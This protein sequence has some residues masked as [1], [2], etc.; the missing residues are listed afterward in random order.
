[1]EELTKSERIQKSIEKD[2]KKVK[3]YQYFLLRLVALLLLIWILLFVVIGVT[4]MP[5]DDMYPRIDGGDIIIFYRLENNIMA[6]DVVVLEKETP[7][8][9]GQKNVYVLRVVAKEG[10][11]VEVTDSKL[12]V[13]NRSMIES[14]I[15]YETY[16]Y[17]GFTEYPIKL[18]KDQ[19]FVMADKRNGGE[20]SRYFGVVNKDE[21]LGRVITILRRNGL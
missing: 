5:N 21:I 8:S 18:E 17:E 10:D 4:H 14:N 6:Q 2:E 20:D 13:N 19:Y 12:L 3:N 11:T 16:Y 15:F 7:D 9:N 1:M